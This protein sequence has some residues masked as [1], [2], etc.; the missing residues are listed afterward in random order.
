MGSRC[1]RT[2]CSISGDAMTEREVEMWW[3][4]QI[5][6]EERKHAGHWDKAT[7]WEFLQKL[8]SKGVE[9]VGRN[10]KEACLANQQ[11][12]LA[13]NAAYEARQSAKSV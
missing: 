13:E 2:Q 6:I 4:E 3:Q 5:R 11:R 8:M 9:M 12:I 10:T 1:S 7:R